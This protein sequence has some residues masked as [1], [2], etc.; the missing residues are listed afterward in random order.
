MEVF[1]YQM[2]AGSEMRVLDC[3]ESIERV[4]AN[5]CTS[6]YVALEGMSVE[7]IIDSDGS[8]TGFWPRLCLAISQRRPSTSPLERMEDRKT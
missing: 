7:G 1:L 5:E 3:L 2:P 4:E 8:L 6:I